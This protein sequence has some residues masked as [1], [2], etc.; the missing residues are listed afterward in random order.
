MSGITDLEKLL[1][2]MDPVI[3]DENFVFC[4]SDR[5]MQELCDLNPWAL[6]KENEGTTIILSE[7]SA[8]DNNLPYECIFKRITL[9]VHSSLEAVGLT[10]AIS[11]KLS[12]FTISANVVAG[13][14]HDHIFVQ[15]DK[16]EEAVEL[17]KEL[18][19][20]AADNQS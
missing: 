7:K 8:K 20:K 9:N 12:E 14:Y 2:T 17:L 6:I 10:A 4:T 1:F 16:A 3:S 5:T 15:K 18:G 11:D 13:Y 19:K